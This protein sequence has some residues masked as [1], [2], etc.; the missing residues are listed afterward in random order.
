MSGAYQTLM[1]LRKK[2]QT[3]S[4][5][6]NILKKIRKSFFVYGYSEMDVE[7]VRNETF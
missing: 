5:Y 6:K 4:C 3:N 7:K 1:E 2:A